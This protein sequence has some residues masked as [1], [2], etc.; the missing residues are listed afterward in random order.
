MAAR[1]PCFGRYRLA[2]I[3]IFVHNV[4]PAVEVG[5]WINFKV[6]IKTKIPA[7]QDSPDVS[8]A[9]ADGVTLLETLESRLSF[10]N[11]RTECYF[12]ENDG[13]IVQTDVKTITNDITAS[14]FELLQTVFGAFDLVAGAIGDL[15][16]QFM[17]PDSTNETADGGATQRDTVKVVQASI[18]LPKTK[19]PQPRKFVDQDEASVKNIKA[20]IFPQGKSATKY[21][22]YDVGQGKTL[23]FN[24]YQR[25]A[26]HLLHRSQ[27]ARIQWPN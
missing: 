6:D 5:K 2:L 15:L 10:P 9:F 24:S 3:S 25:C 4:R 19:K 18:T 14:N 20:A 17:N 12:A 21:N 13:Y 26:N 1:S 16:A 8:G 11:F 7:T 22:L 23:L 27:R